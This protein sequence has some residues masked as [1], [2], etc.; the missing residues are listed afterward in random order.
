MFCQAEGWIDAKLKIA[1]DQNFTDD[2]DLH[3]KMK[4]LKKHQA[5]EAEIRVNGDRM[6]TIREVPLITS[7]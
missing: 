4:L 3:E 5:F 7:N 1:R 6:K 2:T